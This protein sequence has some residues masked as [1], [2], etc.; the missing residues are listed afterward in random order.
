MALAQDG[1]VYLCNRPEGRL[2]VFD[3]MGNFKRN[4][5]IPWRPYTALAPDD[6]NRKSG[7]AGSAVAIA[8][9]RDSKQRFLYV[10]NQND[11]EIEILD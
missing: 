4:M 6:Q 1:M 11:S 9:S 2:E 5:E 3:K 7:A 10:I 8:L